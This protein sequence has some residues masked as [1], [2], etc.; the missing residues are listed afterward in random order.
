MLRSKSIPHDEKLFSICQ[1]NTYAEY[2][3]KLMLRYVTM[4]DDEVGQTVGS[5]VL[6]KHLQSSF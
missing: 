4:L 6:K 5:S 2:G 3:P 1:L